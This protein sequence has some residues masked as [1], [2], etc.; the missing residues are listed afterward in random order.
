M[1]L[2]CITFPHTGVIYT[3]FP[4]HKSFKNTLLL[5][6]IAIPYDLPPHTAHVF[7]ALYHNYISSKIICFLLKINMVEVKVLLSCV[8]ITS[9]RPCLHYRYS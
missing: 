6:S 1:F 5:V 8:Y 4:L 2:G 3:Q 9:L 7:L